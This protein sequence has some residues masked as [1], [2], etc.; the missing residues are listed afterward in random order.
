MPDDQSVL[1]AST[2]IFGLHREGSVTA[3]MSPE[4]RALR[5]ALDTCFPDYDTEKAKWDDIPAKSKLVT[6]NAVMKDKTTKTFTIPVDN[7]ARE[8]VGDTSWK[9]V[10]H[11]QAVLTAVVRSQ[12]VTFVVIFRDSR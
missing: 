8:T 10:Q 1:D 4:Y 11:T 7:L 9:L 3:W 12:I 6:Y 2:G 5:K